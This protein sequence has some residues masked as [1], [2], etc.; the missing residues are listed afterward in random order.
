MASAA[1][2]EQP[3]VILERLAMGETMTGIAKSLGLSRFQ[4]HRVIKSDPQLAEAA[5]AAKAEGCETLLDNIIRIVDGDDMDDQVEIVMDGGVKGFGSRKVKLAALGGDPVARARLRAEYILKTLAVKDP[6]RYGTRLLHAGHDGGTI[7]TESAL[8]VKAIA[9]QLRNAAAARTIEHDAT[10]VVNKVTADSEDR[11]G[12]IAGG[13]VAAPKEKSAALVDCALT[14]SSERLI[15]DRSTTQGEDHDQTDQSIPQTAQPDE[16][17]EA[18]GVH[19]QAP[20]VG[21][22]AAAGGDGV[23]P[24]ARLRAVAPAAIGGERRAK[25]PELPGGAGASQGAGGTGEGGFRGAAGAGGPTAPSA[26]GNTQSTESTKL[27]T[28]WSPEDYV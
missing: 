22:H 19:S 11:R 4:L 7:K 1:L 23:P 9:E 28:D 10:P 27:L 6:A 24:S 13:K 25:S 2:I 20:D 12:K 8:S 26:I 21:V 16:P 14:A 3:D 18:G 15:A 17:R 5:E